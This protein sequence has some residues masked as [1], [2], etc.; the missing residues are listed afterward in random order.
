MLKRLKRVLNRLIGINIDYKSYWE[1]RY[2][3]GGTSGA[4]SYGVLAKF[5]ADVI[6]S[7][8]KKHK[9][10]SIIEFGC[11]DGNQLKYMKYKKYLGCDVARKSVE[12]CARMFKHDQTK[13]FLIYDPRGFVNKGAFKADIV[14]CLDVLYHIIDDWEFK[15]TLQDIFSCSPKFVI[16]YTNIKELKN[17]PGTHIIYRP[18][19]PYLAEFKNYTIDIIIKQKYPRLSLA[20]FVILR[21]ICV[22]KRK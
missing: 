11:G 8:V 7:F 14:V 6:N 3:E 1:E 12:M 13:S 9:A 19:M 10:K 22:N 20:D 17:R 2:S 21:N 5:K 4:G 15:K 16:L 18:L